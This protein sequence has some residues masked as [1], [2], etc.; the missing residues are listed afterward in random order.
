[1]EAHSLNVTPDNARQIALKLRSAVNTCA[2]GL[3]ILNGDTVSG[4]ADSAVLYAA[5]SVIASA[6]TAP[7]VNTGIFLLGCLLFFLPTVSCWA[8]AM[9]FESVGKYMIYG[10]VGGNF[11]FEM[12]TNIILSPVILRLIKIGKKE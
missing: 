4:I 7:V 2:P 10:L 9:G 3:V 8:E 1:M 5:A 12:L 11:L 6:V